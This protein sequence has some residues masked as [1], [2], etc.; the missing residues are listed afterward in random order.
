MTTTRWAA[1]LVVVLL[2]AGCGGEDDDGGDPFSTPPG[3]TST[4][5]G[6]T[7][8]GSEDPCKPHCDGA[9]DTSWF[10]TDGYQAVT[11]VWYCKGNKYISETYENRRGCYALASR[12]TADPICD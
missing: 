8:S 1:A 5:P 11:C 3:S 2:A 10:Q 12:Y 6:S 7:A 4:K 9:D